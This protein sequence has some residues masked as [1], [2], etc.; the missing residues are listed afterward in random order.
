MVL[1]PGFCV[2][3]EQFSARRLIKLKEQHPG[4]A[5]IAHPECDASVLDMADHVSSTTGLL[6]YVAESAH[7]TFIVATEAGILHQ[8]Q[9]RRPEAT[10]VPAPPSSGCNC[11]LCPY[12]RLNTLEKVYLTMRDGRPEIVL[13]E[14]I[15]QR[16]LAPVTR[17]LELG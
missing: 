7:D 17:M 9:K 13:P 8:M 1:W 2:V 6:N 15:R 5:V 11:S 14:D 10:L 4:A 16:A 12:M 3:H